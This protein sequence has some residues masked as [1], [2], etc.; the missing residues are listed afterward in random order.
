VWTSDHID[1]EA[2]RRREQGIPALDRVVTGKQHLS[3]VTGA[4]ITADMATLADAALACILSSSIRQQANADGLGPAD[5]G[6][7]MC[8]NR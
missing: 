2:E 8:V 5:W 1:S 6:K 7:M 3:S 4:D